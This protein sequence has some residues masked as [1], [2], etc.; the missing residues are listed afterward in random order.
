MGLY[1]S[2][3]RGSAKVVGVMA[4]YH[5]IFAE[6]NCGPGIT[7]DNT[8]IEGIVVLYRYNDEK[9]ICS[10]RIADVHEEIA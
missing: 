6:T 2:T 7:G 4:R 9:G 10:Y 5:V 8:K 1:K 3:P